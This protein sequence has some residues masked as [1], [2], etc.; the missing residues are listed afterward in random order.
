[1]TKTKEKVKETKEEEVW[2]DDLWLLILLLLIFPEEPK[3][4]KVINIY[5][6]DDD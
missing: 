6:G 4:K 3:P 5:M 2:V 1:M